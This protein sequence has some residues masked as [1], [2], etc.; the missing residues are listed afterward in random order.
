MFFCYINLLH[1]SYH[2]LEKSNNQILVIL[3]TSKNLVL[4]YVGFTLPKAVIMPNMT[5]KMPPTTGWGMIMKTAPNLLI[6]PWRI[7]NTQAY[8][9]T[10]LLP[11]LETYNDGLN[12]ILI[13]L[14]FIYTFL[15]DQMLVLIIG[16]DYFS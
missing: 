15:C 16:Q 9:I 12:F 8:W 3:K 4:F 2:T 7:I 1:S 14:S 11:T 5:Q 10:L 13:T 6:T